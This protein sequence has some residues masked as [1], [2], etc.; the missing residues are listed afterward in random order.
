MYE[1]FQHVKSIYKDYM[2]SRKSKT[3]T[4]KQQLQQRRVQRHTTKH[5]NVNYLFQIAIN[6]SPNNIANY[7]R[8]A[9][10]VNHE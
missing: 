10:K 9:Y 8:L 5:L 1:P 3:P 2:V 4:K 6:F 7:Q